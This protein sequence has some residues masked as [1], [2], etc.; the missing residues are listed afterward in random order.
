MKARMLWLNIASAPVK[1]VGSG[2][3]WP[4]RRKKSKN[5]WWSTIQSIRQKQPGPRHLSRLTPTGLRL[6]KPLS[7]LGLLDFFGGVWLDGERIRFGAVET[8]RE[9]KNHEAGK[10]Q[11]E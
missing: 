3:C 11:E 1:L 8:N 6:A 10:G 4:P 2:S 9:P 5:G 7:P